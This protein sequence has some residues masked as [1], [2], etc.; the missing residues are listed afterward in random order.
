MKK[1]ISIRNILSCVI[2]AFFFAVFMVLGR[3]FYEDNSWD[4]VFGSPEL[5]KTS[6]LHGIG[7]FILFSVCIAVLFHLLDWLSERKHGE[8]LWPRPVRFYL[9]LLHRHPIAT[10]FFTLLIL[11]LPYMIYS[12]PGILTSD[13]VA[14]LGNGYAALFAKSSS[15]K[16]H[17][18]VVHTLLLYGFTRFGALVFHSTNVGLGLFSLLQIC[19]LFFAIGWLM[20]FL[21]EHHVSARCLGLVLLFYVL[22]P[23]MRNYMFLLVKDTWFAGFLLLFLVELYRILTVRNWSSVEKWQHQGMF[24][25]SVLGIFF[26]RQE[27]VYLIILTS[28]VILIFTRRR[29]FLRLAAFAFAGFLLY[30]QVILPACDVRPSNPRE[31]LSIPFQQTARYLRDA[32]DDVTPEEKAA[33]SAILDYESLP[34]LYNPNLSD[35]VKATYDDETG[36]DELIT[37]FQAWYQM[38]LRH[39]D[40]YVQATMNNLYAYFYPG[41]FTTKLYSYDNSAEHLDELNESLADYGAS[42]HYPAAFDSVRQ[43]LETIRESIFQLPGLIYF[44]YTATYIWILI[45]WFFYCIRRK[46]HK[47]LLLLT[48][49]VIVLLV[50]MAGPTYGWY[51]R[52]AYSIAFCLPAVILT[53]WSEY[54]YDTK[55]IQKITA[56]D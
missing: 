45:L 35:P 42:F 40:I 43:E 22:A 52:Y 13:T 11:Y 27:G 4:L 7:Y 3:S 53:S 47:G 51:F 44:N 33:I 23:R 38:L 18:P 37:Y 19:F 15:L 10:T 50:C 26:F 28:L 31:M 29:F 8:H 9:K 41:G 6:I 14:Q 39:P 24:L 30:T 56:S 17:H 48:P 34:E 36:L 2:P 55:E 49:L 46:N 25:L 54:R 32:G 20:Q 16:N 1:H 21:L 5:L 12:F